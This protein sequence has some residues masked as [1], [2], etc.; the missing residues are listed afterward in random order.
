MTREEAIKILKSKMDGHTD[1]SYEWVEAVRMATNALENEILTT[2]DEMAFP[3]NWHT[4][5][6]Y[7]SFKDKDEVY[8]NG[9]Y[10][11]QK[12]RAEQALEHYADGL[13]DNVLE[14]IDG[15]ND[16]KALA[17]KTSRGHHIHKTLANEIRLAVLALK[18][19][20]LE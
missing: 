8:T 17:D 16:T 12:L 13:I 10:L 19:G 4:F 1:T 7:Y 20:E 5:L 6:D 9:S 15:L 18:E 11:I 14:I 2:Y 3:K